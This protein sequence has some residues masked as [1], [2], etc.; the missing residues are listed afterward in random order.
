MANLGR[1]AA[2]GAG[3]PQ[4]FFLWSNCVALA[5]LVHGLPVVDSDNMWHVGEVITGWLSRWGNLMLTAVIALAAYAQWR[6]GDRLL[7]LQNK[8]D[9]GQNR[10]EV[11]TKLTG[12][13]GLRLTIA[14]L[15]R[16]GILID[17]VNVRM[18]P[19]NAYIPIGVVSRSNTAHHA[20]LSTGYFTLTDGGQQ[21]DFSHKVTVVAT[22]TAN[23]TS[24]SSRPI[25]ANISAHP[26]GNGFVWTIEPA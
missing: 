3:L 1:S 26:S 15:C 25:V 21:H 23:E 4:P 12:G 17:G 11:V 19:K 14:N 10:V 22:F 20:D 7:A 18:G 24:H 13:N 2:T 16:F 9:A 8:I 5:K 6:V